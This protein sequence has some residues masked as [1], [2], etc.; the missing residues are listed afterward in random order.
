MMSDVSFKRVCHK[1][2]SANSSGL[3]WVRASR[4]SRRLSV[5]LMSLVE[6]VTRKE[7]MEAARP[8]P[9]EYSNTRLPWSVSES[10]SEM[11]DARPA[12]TAAVYM[13]PIC[14]GAN[15]AGPTFCA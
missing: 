2:T 14:L 4:R 5:C 9:Y 10:T 8:E 12:H 7:T 15:A 6:P 1:L 3:E 11:S 13:L